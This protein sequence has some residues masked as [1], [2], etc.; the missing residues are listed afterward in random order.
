MVVSNTEVKRQSASRYLK[1]LI[2]FSARSHAIIS[3]SF[4]PNPSGQTTR[5]FHTAQQCDLV[6]VYLAVQNPLFTVELSQL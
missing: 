3:E 1:D 2:G 6:A 4:V 5:F